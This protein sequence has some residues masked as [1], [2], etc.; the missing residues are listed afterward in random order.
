MYPKQ[1]G[2]LLFIAPI[3]FNLLY[4]NWSKGFWNDI[5]HAYEWKLLHI[6]HILS[7]TNKWKFFFQSEHLVELF[8]P[9]L[10]EYSPI[11]YGTVWNYAAFFLNFTGDTFWN[12]RLGNVS[13][14][15]HPNTSTTPC[16]LRWKKHHAIIET[17]GKKRKRSFG[18]IGWFHVYKYNIQFSEG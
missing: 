4:R 18:E 15:H 17:A 7:V 8:V 2:T 10:D 13:S 3:E 12:Y 14:Y 5:W 16:L 9:Y 11:L 1:P 6:S